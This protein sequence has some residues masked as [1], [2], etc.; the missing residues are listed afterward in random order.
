MRFLCLPW[1]QH[2]RVDRGLCKNNM[3]REG[4]MTASHKPA[5]AV[6][7]RLRGG[8]LGRDG[9]SSYLAPRGRSRVLRGLARRRP[10]T[11]RS[12]LLGHDHDWRESPGIAHSVRLR[13]LPTPSSISALQLPLCC[14]EP[15]VP[16]P[17]LVRPPSGMPIARC[18]LPLLPVDGNIFSHRTSCH[19]QTHTATA[20]GSPL[21]STGH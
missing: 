7:M 14:P 5:P 10:R 9:A 6:R 12:A 19:Q 16:P 11:G 15:F 4:P 1:G 2:K 18:L 3:E 21:P 20:A 17:G 13:H 8:R